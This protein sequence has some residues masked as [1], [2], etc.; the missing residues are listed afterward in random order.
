MKNSS[1]IPLH[2]NA[3]KYKL[4]AVSPKVSKNCKNWKGS[5]YGH[6][7]ELISERSGRE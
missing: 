7:F 1:R 2:S 5:S 4:T 3:K 6:G